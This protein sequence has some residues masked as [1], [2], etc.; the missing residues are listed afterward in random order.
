MP[1]DDVGEAYARRPKAF[2]EAEWRARVDV[3]ACYRL[4]ANRWGA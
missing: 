4:V 2:G 3:A 1:C